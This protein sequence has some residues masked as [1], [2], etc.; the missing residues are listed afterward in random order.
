MESYKFN[1][2]IGD[3]SG[4]GHYKCKKYT[5]ESN[6]KPDEL[7]IVYTKTAR[8]IGYSPSDCCVEY[9]E[10]IITLNQFEQLQLNPQKYVELLDED[11]IYYFNPIDFCK[12]IIDFITTHNHGVIMKIVPNNLPSWDLGNIGY[13]LFY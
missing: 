11:G 2:S 5:I 6:F 8:D 3:V 7:H 1:L 4:D 12:L 9:E 10:S 13:G